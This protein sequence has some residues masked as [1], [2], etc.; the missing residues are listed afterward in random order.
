MDSLV[1]KH[2][3]EI[4]A[5]MIHYQ[6]EHASVFGSA[7]KGNFDEN[8]DIDFLIKFNPSLDYESYS[9]NYFGLLYA[10]QKLLNRDVELVAEETVTNKY[11]EES[12]NESKVAIL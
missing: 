11:F 2:I 6:V 8:S 10:L 12:I 3:N 1:E 7:V 5:L 4:K 9:D